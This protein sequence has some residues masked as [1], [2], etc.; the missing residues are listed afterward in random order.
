MYY[1]YQYGLQD[2]DWW[3]GYFLLGFDID[4]HQPAQKKKILWAPG[5]Y[6]GSD[7]RKKT[8]VDLLS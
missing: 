6:V 8:R 2:S 3:D 7:I 5:K 4:A 1:R